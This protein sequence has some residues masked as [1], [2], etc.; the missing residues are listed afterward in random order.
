MEKVCKKTHKK[1]KSQE[2]SALVNAQ[3]IHTQNKKHATL[4][5]LE[6]LRENIKRDSLVIG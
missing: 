4:R 5:P 6:R 3:K 2:G 1:I